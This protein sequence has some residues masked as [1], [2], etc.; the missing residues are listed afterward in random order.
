MFEALL[1]WYERGF[2]GLEKIVREVPMDLHLYFHIYIYMKS[3]IDIQ[4]FGSKTFDFIQNLLLQ[5][6]D[7]NFKLCSIYCTG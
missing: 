4:E 2:K 5:M 7:L 1:F 3:Y 6:Y